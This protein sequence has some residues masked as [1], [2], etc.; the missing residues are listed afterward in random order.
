M[1]VVPYLLILGILG[2]GFYISDD[3]NNRIYENA[4][5]VTELTYHYHLMDR[6]EGNSP[7]LPRSTDNGELLWKLDGI[8]GWY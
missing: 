7:G 2:I 3:Y 8:R 5:S 4:S 6:N 1:D